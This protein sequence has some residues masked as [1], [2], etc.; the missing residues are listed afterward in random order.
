MKRDRGL[1]RITERAYEFARS[2]AYE[3]MASLE[4]RLA[5]VKQKLEDTERQAIL[6]QEHRLGDMRN[7]HHQIIEEPVELAHRIWRG[8][9]VIISLH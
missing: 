2:G 5:Q 1:A 6:G 7:A 9:A 3:N 4:R 8:G